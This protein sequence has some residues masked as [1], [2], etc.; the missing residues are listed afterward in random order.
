MPRSVEPLLR[1]R[2]LA[3]TATLAISRVPALTVTAPV[4]MAFALLT[5]IVPLV[6]V[7]VPVKAVLL[8]LKFN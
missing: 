3:I 1:V 6:T 5:E 7:V 4:P 2:L 8:P